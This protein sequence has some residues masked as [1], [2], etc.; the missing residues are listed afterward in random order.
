MYDRGKGVAKD[1]KTAVKWYKL[2]AEQ[3]HARAQY[4]LKT[5]QQKIAKSKQK[6][7]EN[8][9]PSPFETAKQQCA[10]LGF[11]EGTEKFGDCVVKLYK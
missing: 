9:K 5:L 8:T 11:K 4:Y 1:D 3:G 6:T 10:S 2:A 7:G